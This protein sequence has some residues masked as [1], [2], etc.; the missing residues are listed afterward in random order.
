MTV[1]GC[2]L[3]LHAIQLVACAG[4]EKTGGTGVNI[5]GSSDYLI[6]LIK[7][8]HRP[9]MDKERKQLLDGPSD[10]LPCPSTRAAR[11]KSKAWRVTLAVVLGFFWIVYSLFRFHTS[12]SAPFDPEVKARC[13]T[14]METPKGYYTSRMDRLVETLKE[15][16]ATWIAEPGPSADYYLGGFAKPDWHLSERPLLV[17]IQS[18]GKVTILTPKFEELRARGVGRTAEVD[19][20]WVSW[21]E[22]DSPYQVLSDTLGDTTLVV[23]AQVRSFIAEEMVSTGKVKMAPVEVG[24][25]ISLLR[26]RKDEREIGLLRCANQ[27][28]LHAIRETRKRMHLG[29]SESETRTILD[30]ELAKTGVDG[31]GGLV[32]FGGE[33]SNRFRADPHR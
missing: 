1:S 8:H 10:G 15:H 16:D 18:T 9:N 25:S 33:F 29:V 30:E 14:L 23:D 27:M 19:V 20:A 7:H 17:A 2:K 22:N 6:A 24:K 21:A 5:M 32:L 12:T 26:E 28:T 31:E 4:P 11:T 13:E 3:R